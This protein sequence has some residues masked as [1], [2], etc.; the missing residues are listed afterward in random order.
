MLL[1]PENQ[2]TTKAKLI[3]ISNPSFEKKNTLLRPSHNPLP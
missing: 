3:P 2:A 1:T